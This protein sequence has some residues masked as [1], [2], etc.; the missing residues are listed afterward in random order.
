MDLALLSLCLVVGLRCKS[1][2]TGLA[3]AFLEMNVRMEAA[4]SV[5]KAPFLPNVMSAQAT[6]Q[7]LQQQKSTNTGVKGASA[8]SLDTA[9]V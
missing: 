7:K 5:C 4:F 6:V 2:L 8:H 9:I 3:L 1:L